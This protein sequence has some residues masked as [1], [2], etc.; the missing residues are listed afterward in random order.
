[1][2]CTGMITMSMRE[3]DRLKVIEAVAEARLMPWR[4]AERLG[5]SVRQIERLVIRYREH[6]AQG[7]TS[8]KR[9]RHARGVR[10]GANSS[11]GYG[12]LPGPVQIDWPRMTCGWPALTT[13]N[14][15][16]TGFYLTPNRELHGKLHP[17]IRINQ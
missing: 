12:G 9:G 15:T 8:C 4:A 17:D 13:S 5:L 3:L 1:M 14:C 10:A 7:V 6:G 16:T 2:A 11:K